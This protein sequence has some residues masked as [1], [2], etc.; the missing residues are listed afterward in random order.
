MKN[1]RMKF[2]LML[3]FLIVASEVSS[4]E[5]A[6]TIDDAPRGDELI[7]SGNARTEQFIS[8]LKN[9]GIQ[10]VFFCNSVRFGE[11]NGKERIQ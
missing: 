1:R 7:Y 5:V 4:R 8:I 11:S 6:L 9:E 10:T 2:L 3:S